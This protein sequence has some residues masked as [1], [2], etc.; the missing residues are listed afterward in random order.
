M[1]KDLEDVNYR[2]FESADELGPIFD[3]FL[4]DIAN[5]QQEF[6]SLSMDRRFMGILINEQNDDRQ[7]ATTMAT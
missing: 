5:K 3:D 1:L 6:V 2:S 4:R 7:P